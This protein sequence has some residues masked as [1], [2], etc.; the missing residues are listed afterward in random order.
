MIDEVCRWRGIRVSNSSGFFFKRNGTESQGWRS[1]FLWS[2]LEIAIYNSKVP[3][4]FITAAPIKQLRLIKVHVV[5]PHKVSTSSR[6]FV[7]RDLSEPLSLHSALK[8]ASL[9]SPLASNTAINFQA[10]HY[11]DAKVAA[12]RKA[13]N[14]SFRIVELIHDTLREPM[15]VYR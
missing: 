11:F 2:R 1:S 14:P 7:S 9:L 15:L 4:R 12:K 13:F 8:I 5:T 6:G 3:K 10:R